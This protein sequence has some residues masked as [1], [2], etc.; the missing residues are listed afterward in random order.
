[1]NGLD[2]SEEKLPQ[3]HGGT[4]SPYA[5]CPAVTAE[6]DLII[7]HSD[8]YDPVSLRDPMFLHTEINKLW[9]VHRQYDGDIKVERTKMLAVGRWSE[10]LDF[11]PVLA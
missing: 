1:V 3:R 7:P 2:H 11:A 6:A 8:L 4:E 9:E 5:D 10:I